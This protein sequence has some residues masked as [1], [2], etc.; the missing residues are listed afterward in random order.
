MK[1]VR[2]KYM[3]KTS[4]PNPVEIL[5]VRRSAVDAEDL[6]PPME[7]SHNLKNK[8]PSDT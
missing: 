2:L 1:F 6:R 7:P 4:M 5:T 8:T 3:K